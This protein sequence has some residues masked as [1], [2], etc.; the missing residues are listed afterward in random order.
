MK[1]H[2]LLLRIALR[3]GENPR[4]SIVQQVVYRWAGCHQVELLCCLLVQ[5]C[6]FLSTGLYRALTS[7]ASLSRSLLCSTC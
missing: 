6:D 7:I 4:S 2:V 1:L 3:L 5:M